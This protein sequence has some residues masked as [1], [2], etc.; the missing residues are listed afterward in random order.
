MRQQLRDLHEVQK[1]DLEIRELE[2]RHDGIP[3]KLKELETQIASFAEQT[4]KL[5]EQR[6]GLVREAKIVEGQIQAE[7]HKIRKWTARLADIRNQREYLALSREIEGSKRANKQAEEKLAELGAAKDK[8]V[9]EIASLQEHAEA[10]KAALALERR[11]V[12]SSGAD[13]REQIAQHKARRENLLPAIP[14]ALMRKY[15]AIRAKRLGQGLVSVTAGSCCGCNMK[16]PPQLYNILQRGDSIEQ[17]PT[18][19]R[20]VVWDQFLANGDNTAV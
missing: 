7:A 6:E 4:A 14:T 8:L 3:A 18:C 12:D 1:I 13:V 19:L 20:L 9:G 17:C 5:A 11:Q 10:A 16:L 2:R 15:E